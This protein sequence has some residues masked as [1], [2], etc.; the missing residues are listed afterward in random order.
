MCAVRQ[1]SRAYVARFRGIHIGVRGCA[2]GTAYFIPA[3]AGAWL[4]WCSSWGR[5]GDSG[6]S[7]RRRAAAPLAAPLARVPWDR[8]F[9]KFVQGTGVP[10]CV[11]LI[12]IYKVS[13]R[14][15]V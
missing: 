12:E 5:L 9:S 10:G 1:G 2:P 8:C 6:L 11:L 15:Q 13:S 7:P 14:T 3:R 4:V